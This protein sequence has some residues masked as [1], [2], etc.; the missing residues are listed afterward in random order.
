MR[1][2]PANGDSHRS[3][4]VPSSTGRRPVPPGAQGGELGAAQPGDGAEAGVVD[5]GVAVAAPLVADAEAGDVFAGRTFFPGSPRALEPGE[6]EVEVW[7]TACWDICIA[8]LLN[9]V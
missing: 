3:P 2:F 5:D 4:G 6:G 7:D 8:I 1:V 9:D